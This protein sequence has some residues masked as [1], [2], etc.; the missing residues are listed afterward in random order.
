M[1]IRRLRIQFRRKD[2]NFRIKRSSIFLVIQK[3]VSDTSLA[4]SLE[5]TTQSGEEFRLKNRQIIIR[6][7]QYHI[8]KSDSRIQAVNKSFKQLV[9]HRKYVVPVTTKNRINNFSIHDRMTSQ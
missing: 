1:I 3:S 5:I 7:L 4:I 9:K 2:I 6:A 8:Y